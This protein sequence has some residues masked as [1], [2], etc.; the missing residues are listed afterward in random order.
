MRPVR[1]GGR[2]ADGDEI[3]AA[4]ARADGSADTAEAVASTDALGADV[5]RRL[6]A[7]AGADGGNLLLSPAS[8]E[9]ALAM[10][11]TGAAGETRAQ[12]ER[13]LHAGPGDD[14][15]ASLNALD[16]VLASRSGD[17]SNPARSGEVSLA[18]ASSLWGQQR[19]AFEQPFLEGLARDYGAGMHL[20]DYAEDTE[21]ARRTI[22]Q[23]VADRTN[24]KIPDLLPDGSVDGLTRLVLANALYLKA[25]WAKAFT[26][27]GS[28]PFTHADGTTTSAPAMTVGK[29]ASVSSGAG[30]RAATIPYLGNELAMTVIVPDDL[31]AFEASLDG[32]ALASIRSAPTQLLGSLQMPLFTFRSKAQLQ[33]PLSAAGMPLAF[34][35]QA[36]DFSAMTSADHLCVSDIHHQAFIA[37][38]EEGTEAAAATGVVIEAIS[39]LS[40]NMTVDRPFLFVIRDDATG[41]TLFLGRVTDPTAT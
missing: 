28:Q 11:R 26:G 23:W 16:L 1:G 7:S 2:P 12:M 38:D 4:V 31:H 39:A 10:T 33:A 27:I 15:D 41:A 34:D 19:F 21:G 18:V 30:W 35:E 36:A 24:A 32:S 25:P 29:G 14:L 13:V 8:I 40:T 5:F 17:R 9:L 37:V 3:S 20:V 22:N 6:A